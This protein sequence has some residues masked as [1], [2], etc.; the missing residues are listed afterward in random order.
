MILISFIRQH[1]RVLLLVWTLA[2]V[3]AAGAGVWSAR[4]VQAQS[5]PAECT[6]AFAIH[7][8]TLRETLEIVVPTQDLTQ[9]NRVTVGGTVVYEAY[10]RI[11]IRDSS[12]TRYIRGT[13][14]RWIDHHSETPSYYHLDFFTGRTYGS[15]SYI[16]SIEDG[17]TDRITVDDDQ[18]INLRIQF[19]PAAGKSSARVALYFQRV[20]A[21]NSGTYPISDTPT[22]RPATD[23][24]TALS[25]VSVPGAYNDV[26]I[27]AGGCPYANSNHDVRYT[28]GLTLAHTG[29]MDVHAE[30]VSPARMW[31][32]SSQAQVLRKLL[33]ARL[34]A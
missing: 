13:M 12:N 24:H 16:G 23:C 26:S 7:A 32:R 21:T 29:Q 5:P 34:G 2:I 22:P 6:R 9:C 19:T 3:M 18:T 28:L 30:R 31:N 8:T 11:S 10:A 4:D 33:P 25:S 1:S 14:E 15:G 17:A 27:A 20:L